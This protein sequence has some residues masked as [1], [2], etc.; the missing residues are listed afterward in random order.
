[1]SLKKTTEQFSKEVKE[2]TN[3]EYEVLGEYQNN[4]TKIKIKHITCGNV[5]EVRPN[6]FQ[7]GYRCPKCSNEYNNGKKYDLVKSILDDMDIEYKLEA[8]FKR[9]YKERKLRFDFFIKELNLII[10]VDGGQHFRASSGSFMSYEIGNRVENDWIKNIWCYKNKVKI[11]RIPYSL[12]ET[13]IKESLI[14]YFKNNDCNCLIDNNIYYFD[15]KF[16]FNKVSYYSKRNFMYFSRYCKFIEK[17]EMYFI[18]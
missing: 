1:M 11:I 7:Q 14:A 3:G 17:A 2:M 13:K 12:C 10:E 15:G 18:Y 16:T 6:D 9:L 4:K 8:K 5:Y